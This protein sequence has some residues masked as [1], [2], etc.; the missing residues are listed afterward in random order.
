MTQPAT[1]PH[2][3]NPLAQQ[4]AG[5]LADDPPSHVAPEDDDFADLASQVESLLTSTPVE[6][7]PPP[8]STP[9]HTPPPPA[10][11]TAAATAEHEAPPV[12][13]D[14]TSQVA[15]LLDA[16]ERPPE[17]LEAIDH[18]L[19]Q[20]TET[21]LTDPTA[22]NPA[23]DVPPVPHAGPAPAAAAPSASSAHAD[24]PR[25]SPPIPASAPPA[26]TSAPDVA[27]PAPPA[28]V[29]T[30]STPRL[31]RLLTPMGAVLGRPLASQPRGVRDSI[32]WLALWTLSCGVFVWVYTL[33]LHS[34]RLPQTPPGAPAI[35]TPETKAA[36]DHGADEPE[37][38]PS[39]RPQPH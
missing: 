20:L 31:T 17:S 22:A 32:G 10:P 36:K 27:S 33:F 6:T 3:T 11:A 39:R 38:P 12:V 26:S 15:S 8:P 2:D 16:G 34:P 1:Q 19:A 25:P 37:P 21:L 30:T 24:T 5:L 35:T 9:I 23:P 18:D 13:G 4:V 29:G 14:L 7:P 28:A